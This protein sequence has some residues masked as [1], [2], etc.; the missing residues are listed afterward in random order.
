[1]IT[2]FSIRAR[3]AFGFL[4]K[5]GFQ[6][7]EDEY[8]SVVYR[9]SVCEVT[10][11]YDDQRS[12]EVSLNIARLYPVDKP[13]FSFEEILRA[14]SVPK[15]EW[16]T[17]YSARTL[18]DAALLVE[19]MAKIFRAYAIQLIEGDTYAW[20]R[21][22]DQRKIDC[23]NYAKETRLNHARSQADAAWAKRD[24]ARVIVALESVDVVWLSKSELAKLTYARRNV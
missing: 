12:F 24:Y 8:A 6:I 17:G 4:T 16:P 9:S 10:L 7:I 18:D 20:K 22:E 3:N 19:Q 13:S 14:Q 11:F 15:N 23:L 2:Y 21:I 5:H 1:M